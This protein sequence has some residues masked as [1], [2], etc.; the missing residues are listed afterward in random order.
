MAVDLKIVVTDA[1]PLVTLAAARS[2]SYLLYPELPIIVPDAV[3][4]EAT[5]AIS[6]L[7]AQDI[8][9]WYRKHVDK[10][11]IEPTAAFQNETTLLALGQ[12][13][14][15]LPRDLGERAALEVIRDSDL[16]KPDEKAI[17]L[18]DDRDAERLIVVDPS[19]TVLLTTWDFLQQLEA[20]QRIQSAD[21]V[22]EMARAAGRDVP[23]R[24]LWSRHDPSVKD[25]VKSILSK[26]P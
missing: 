22:V 5:A 12:A 7:G 1:P 20:A 8:I 18:S 17:L 10:I 4:Y 2:L 19:K 13:T 23:K 25:A 21:A 15:R 6:K 3:F 24:D 26:R 11:H 16:L 9:N 14:G